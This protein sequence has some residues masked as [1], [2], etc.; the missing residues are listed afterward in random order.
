MTL[1]RRIDHWLFKSVSLLAQLFLIGAVA[2]GFWQV[3]ARFVL[4][5]PLDWSEVLTRALLIWAVLLGVVLAFRQGAM[6]GVEILRSLLRGAQRR[7][8]EWLVA[9]VCSGFLGFLSWIG[10]QMTWRVRFQTVPSLD[11]SISWVYL[12]I[13]LGAA[14]AA[15]AVLIQVAVGAEQAPAPLDGQG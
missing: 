10:G 6:L 14:L 4:S 5:S 11:I 13:P 8:L 7:V 2:A 9:L 15:I 3:I 12:A 1:L